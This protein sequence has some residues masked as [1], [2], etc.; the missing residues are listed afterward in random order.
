MGI[1][2]SLEPVKQAKLIF[3]I[4]KNILPSAYIGD[5]DDTNVRRDIFTT[6]HKLARVVELRESKAKAIEYLRTKFADEKGLEEALKNE[7]QCLSPR[8]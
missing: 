1:K 5:H 6:V 2:N 3:I 8:P 4:P 7:I